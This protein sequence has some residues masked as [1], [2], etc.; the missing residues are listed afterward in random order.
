V[1]NQTLVKRDRSGPLRRDR[2]GERQVTR[3]LTRHLSRIERTAALATV[4][5]GELG[6]VRRY[7]ASKAIATVVKAQHVV[8]AAGHAGWMTA[9]R[10]AQFECLTQAYLDAVTRI[11]EDA[12][13][14]IIA[15]LVGEE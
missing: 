4:G 11:T 9:D 10:Q 13:Q 8:S 2:L 6:A 14:A 7:V 15:R 1:S 12:A 3:E 5:I